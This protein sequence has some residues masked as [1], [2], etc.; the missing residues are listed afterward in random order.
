MGGN[1]LFKRR[2]GFSGTPSELLPRDLGKCAFEPGSEGAI[3]HT[4]TSPE[5]MSAF[6]FGKVIVSMI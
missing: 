2:I 1:M 5:I 3:V 4:L 6:L